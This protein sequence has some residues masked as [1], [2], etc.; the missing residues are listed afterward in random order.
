MSMSAKFDWNVVC[1]AELVGAAIAG[2]TAAFAEIYD[3]YAN[4]LYDFC[5]GIVGDRDAADCVQEAF[6]N[7]VVDLPKLRDP[8]K[9]RPWLY[10]I[11]RHQA[12][13]TLRARQRETVSDDLPDEPDSGAG[14]D[15][16][17]ARNELAALVAH[18]E[19]G[20]SQRDREVLDLAYRHGLTNVEIAETLGVS[21]AS[22]KKIVQRLRDTIEQSL[23]AL[24]V[25]RHAAAG[26]NRCPELSSVIAGWDGQF[27][28]LVRKRIS[29][30]LASCP[31]CDEDRGRLV[32]PTAL[33]GGAPVLIPAP[34]W[35]REQTLS[36]ASHS[37]ASAT[38][39]AA[40]AGHVVKHVPAQLFA[41]TGRL[42]L[43]A[44][45]IVAVPAVIWGMTTG[46]PAPQDTQ[47]TAVT[48]ATSVELKPVVPS[49]IPALLSSSTP[50]PQPSVPAIEPS[51]SVPPSSGLMTTDAPNPENPG[52]SPIEQAPP[53]PETTAAASSSTP[54]VTRITHVAPASS[55]PKA[56]SASRQ[57]A[58]QQ[59]PAK[60]CPDGSTVDNGQSC[61]T[62]QAPSTPNCPHVAVP[63]NPI[64]GRTADGK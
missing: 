5:V 7:A 4:R 51:G 11:A 8:D 12:F 28:I 26:Q 9:L 58:P 53:P 60:H 27:T 23:G 18:A 24:L 61:P 33:L 1:D 17:A 36:N 34:E 39:A 56:P 63:S 16:Q 57:R 46:A 3:R 35:L 48:S 41:L 19:G 10:A 31:N 22:A 38:A 6:C 47:V 45:S 2:D 55:E 32:N 62:P 15:T 52:N 37:P 59:P 44:A 29:R 21:S 50:A 40:A 43:L 42:T 49:T 14:P 20:L 30:H 64:C 54:T 13:R 25:A